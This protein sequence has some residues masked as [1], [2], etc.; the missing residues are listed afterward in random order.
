MTKLLCEAGNDD[1][2]ELQCDQEYGHDGPHTHQEQGA[3]WMNAPKR[4]DAHTVDITLN[5]AAH[6]TVLVDGQPVQDLVVGITMLALPGKG[7]RVVL[8]LAAAV[9]LRSDVGAVELG[10][11]TEE[12]LKRLGW[13]PP[14][15]PKLPVASEG[16]RVQD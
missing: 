2:P 7:P 16:N 13:T 4:P 5:N 6:G 12:L 8:E 11:D 10:T 3:E 1:Y 9:R 15:A 14:A